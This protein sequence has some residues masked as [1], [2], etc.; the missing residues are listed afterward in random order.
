MGAGVLSLP[1]PPH[2]NH[3][4]Q[5]KF[6]GGY[7]SLETEAPRMPKKAPKASKRMRHEHE[8]P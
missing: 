5:R 3:V 8:R 1:S 7:S 6:T 4:G 2:F